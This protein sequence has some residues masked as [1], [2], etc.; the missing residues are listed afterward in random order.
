MISRSWK[1]N[2]QRLIPFF[3]YPE[4]IRKVIYTTNA[5]ESIN[6]N[7]RKVIKTKSSFPNDTAFLKIIY[8]RLRL[9]SKKW[10]LPI[11]NWKEALNQFSIIFGNRF[12]EN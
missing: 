12:P 7:L 3:D 11:R 2:W 8:L 6:M 5:I 4:Y 1:A 9:I 10:T